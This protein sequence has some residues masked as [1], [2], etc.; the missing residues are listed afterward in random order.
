[1]SKLHFLYG[2]AAVDVLGTFLFLCML[3]FF[4]RRQRQIE[5]AVDEDTI[6]IC[7]YTVTVKGLPDD[8][9]D[10]E[11]V[12]CFFELKFGKVVDAVLA[13]N[14]GILLTLY[15]QRWGREGVVEQPR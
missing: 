6:E 15:R 8:A 11:E 10:K 4:A 12:R 5:K 1:M 9:S 3:M 7:D 2:S 14:D 13:K